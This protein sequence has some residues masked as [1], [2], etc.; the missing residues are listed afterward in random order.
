MLIVSRQQHK[1]DPYETLTDECTVIVSAEFGSWHESFLAGPPFSGCLTRSNTRWTGRFLAFV[2]V[3]MVWESP[4]TLCDRFRTAR[5]VVTGM[6]FSSR[7]VGKTYQGFIKAL[8]R[9]SDT[10]VDKI[11]DHTRSVIQQ[12]AGPYWTREQF[13]AFA[14]DG[15]RMECPRTEANETALGCGGRKGTGPQFWLT[16]LWHMGTGLPW[17]WKIGRSTDAER[18]H[19]RSMLPLLPD[20][21][22]LV[23]DAGFTGYELFREILSAGRSLLIRV[24][25]NVRLLQKL[26]YTEI[27]NEQTVYLW[28]D[29]FQKSNHPPLV[30]RMIIL[31]RKG[32]KIY[33]LTNLSDEQLSDERAG[34]LYEMRWG[35]EVFYRSMKQTLSRRKM[36]S[37]APKQARAELGWTLVGLQLLG[38][39][40]VEQIIHRGKDPL[41]WSVAAS[42]RVVR[43]AMREVGSRRLARRGLLRALSL[44]TKDE[45][46][47]RRPKKARDWPHKKKENPPEPPKFRKANE[48]EVKKAQEVKDAKIAA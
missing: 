20:N 17:A 34:I 36:L 38:L 16:T 28:P 14:V 30:L 42:L 27:E 6:F 41:S 39:L 46:K 25:S 31:Q 47:R 29:G 8:L 18:T 22:L 3:L 23:A 2:A 37:R 21:A 5:D 12:I 26:G 32:K 13:V 4:Q 35:V 43:L 45:Y 9:W 1:G 48:T 19:L 24:G 40:S 33:L 44:A 10:L 11:A 15:S 7:R